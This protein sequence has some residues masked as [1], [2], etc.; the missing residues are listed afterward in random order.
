MVEDR[1]VCLPRSPE[2]LL[3]TLAALHVETRPE[4]QPGHGGHGVT[5]CNQAAEA[6][7]KALECPLPP[8]LLANAQQGWLD[9]AAAR[10]LGWVECTAEHAGERA[11]GGFPTF[12]TY[13]EEPHGHIGV[14]TVGRGPGL[15][16]WQ[17]GRTNRERAS[18]R[19][20]FTVAQLL[21]VRYFTHV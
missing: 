11:E 8:G 7:A 14:V 12:A 4:W 3:S 18:I 19:L 5:W 1:N 2:L 13:F 21:K 16:L 17:A 10:S 9:S 20:C 6:A 15:Y